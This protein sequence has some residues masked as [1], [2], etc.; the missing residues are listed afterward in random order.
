MKDD[1]KPAEIAKG[2]GTALEDIP[3]VVE[4]LG[5]LTRNSLLVGLLH[6]LVFG[7]QAKVYY[8]FWE[9]G[10]TE[11]LNGG[12]CVLDINAFTVPRIFTSLKRL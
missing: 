11:P 3:N 5:R 2:K 8:A 12:G 10:F 1:S 4:K 7:G 6:N 9:S